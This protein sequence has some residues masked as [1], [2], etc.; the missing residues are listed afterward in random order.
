MLRDLVVS[1]KT[2]TELSG[3]VGIA[4]M[5]GKVAKQGAW[6]LAQFAAILSINLAVVNL[7]PIPALDGGRL[8][9]VLI[10]VL[11]RKRRSLVWEARLHQIGFLLLISLIVLVT[12]KDIRT[13]GAP[14]WQGIKQFVGL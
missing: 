7:L 9:F 10:E 4:V 13:Y 11:R 12:A 1:Q 2:S 5:T 6:A 8:V 14:V 3:P